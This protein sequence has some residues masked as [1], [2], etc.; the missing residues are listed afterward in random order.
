M[1]GGDGGGVMHRVAVALGRAGR[2][3]GADEMA[4]AMLTS[5][6]Q[7]ADALDATPGSAALWAQWLRCLHD[8]RGGVVEA[9]DAQMRLAE[10]LTGIMEPVT[11]DLVWTRQGAVKVSGG[12]A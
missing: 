2:R 3:G 6:V 8:I 7:L 5:L 4:E 10:T 1:A 11:G 9:D 12:A